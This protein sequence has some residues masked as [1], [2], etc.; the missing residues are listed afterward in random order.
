MTFINQED[1]I[2]ES[3]ECESAES[4]ARPDQVL[5]R[6]LWRQNQLWICRVNQSEYHVLLPALAQPDWCQACLAHSQVTA[7][8]IDPVL[9][10]A[11]IHYW[12]EACRA[13][14]KPLY[15]RLP[16]RHTLPE[17]QRRLT[18]RLKCCTERLL[19]LLALAL[20]GPLM[21]AI[22]LAVWRDGGAA[23]TYYWCVGCR[24]QVFRMAQF[25]TRSATTRELTRLGYWLQR[26]RLDRLPRLL[27]VVRG[28]MALVGTKPWTIEDALKIAPEFRFCLKAMPGVMGPRPLGLNVP[29][30]DVGAIAEVD[31]SY[32]MGWSLWRDGLTAATAMVRVMTGE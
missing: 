8:V 14:E 31:L 5:C 9:D 29:V 3:L 28:E 25:R 32:L 22:A 2:S 16:T 4:S 17:K 24:G 19:G 26:W 20:L 11:A 10:L 21:L 27:N 1:G 13:T 7:V 15:L 23:L 12:A 6:L 18:W 30:V